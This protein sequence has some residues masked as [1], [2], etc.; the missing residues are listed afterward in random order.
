MADSVV[1]GKSE[2]VWVNIRVNVNIKVMM[3]NIYSSL[4]PKEIDVVFPWPFFLS[5]FCQ[6]CFFPHVWT[7]GAH[8]LPDTS[9]IGTIVCISFEKL[10]LWLYFPS[11]SISM[12]VSVYV[13]IIATTKMRWSEKL[14]FQHS[15]HL[16]FIRFN[17][18][19]WKTWSCN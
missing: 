1:Q 15:H 16:P 9:N 17:H 13:R 19:F 3:W 14:S 5:P 12:Y 10:V 6:P 4:S 7:L 8:I 11:V 18:P 2:N